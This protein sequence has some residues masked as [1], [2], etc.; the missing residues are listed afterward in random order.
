MN[1]S[2]S[3]F[4]KPRLGKAPPIKAKGVSLIELM[5][6]IVLGMLAVLAVLSIYLVMARTHATG[7]NLARIQEN[8]RIAFELMASDIRDAGLILCGSDLPLI[9]TLPQTPAAPATPFFWWNAQAVRGYQAGLEVAGR[10]TGIQAGD[11]TANTEAMQVSASRGNGIGISNFTPG[12]PATFT[13][14]NAA[15]GFGANEAVV[16]C[17]QNQAHLTRINPSHLPPASTSTVTTTLEANPAYQGNSIMAA[18]STTLWYVGCTG[19]GDCA[20][21]GGRALYRIVSGEANSPP[22]EVISDVSDMRVRYLV[23]GEPPPYE[24]ADFYRSADEVAAHQWV[25]VTA[26]RITLTFHSTDRNVAT[27]SARDGRLFR[28]VTHTIALRNRV[29]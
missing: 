27:E 15:H 20:Q 23:R 2:A 6:G 25:N 17:N 9:N 28:E 11:R 1:Q 21:P 14:P 26:L 8:T 22:E 13:L 4:L 3:R 16:V 29:P 24:G 12:S 5:I 18:Y 10:P 7:D 19:R